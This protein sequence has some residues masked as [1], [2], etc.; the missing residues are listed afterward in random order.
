MRRRT[1]WK[2]GLQISLIRPDDDKAAVRF[3]GEFHRSGC[4]EAD[5]A[6]AE[7]KIAETQT[8]AYETAATYLRKVHRLLTKNKREKEWQEY[9]TALRQ[10]YRRKRSLME[11]L[12]H[13]EDRRIIGR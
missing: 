7:R 2:S 4:D 9:L 6:L 8:R 1:D 11:I 3:H 12:N 13:I 10:T 5:Y